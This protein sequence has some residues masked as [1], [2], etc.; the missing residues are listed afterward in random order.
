[1]CVTPAGKIGNWTCGMPKSLPHSRLKITPS[2][3]LQTGSNRLIS[4]PFLSMSTPKGSGVLNLELRLSEASRPNRNHNVFWGFSGPR[5][6][7][8][9]PNRKRAYFRSSLACDPLQTAALPACDRRNDADFVARSD[10]G[11][12][13]FQKAYIF[14]IQ[15]DV[16]KPANMIMVV[17]DALFQTGI[18][19][20]ETSDHFAD[21]CTIGFNDLLVLG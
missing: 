7:L 8:G 5:R 21:R 9:T 19:P 1:M 13:F 10:W 20:I 14:V 6:K 2:F 16:N 17:A 3:S 11:L 12:G 18:G 15:E 4:L